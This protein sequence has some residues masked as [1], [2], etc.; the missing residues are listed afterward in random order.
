MLIASIA[1]AASLGT[2]TD[3][4][5]N[6]LKTNRQFFETDKTL[7]A[8][9]K[10]CVAPLK[11]QERKAFIDGWKKWVIS[12]RQEAEKRFAKMSPAY[13]Q[14]LIDH[15]ALQSDAKSK[16][17]SGRVG[18]IKGDD[19]FLTLDYDN[20]PYDGIIK[21]EHRLNNDETET[22]DNDHDYSLIWY[23]FQI[24]T[25]CQ[26]AVQLLQKEGIDALIER[27]QIDMKENPLDKN[28]LRITELE[29]WLKANLAEIHNNRVSQGQIKEKNAQI[30]SQMITEIC[31]WYKWGGD[32]S[33]PRYKEA[34]QRML[35]LYYDAMTSK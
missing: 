8:V 9:F 15:M 19:Y 7:N 25:Y 26:E 13:V 31:G 29:G 12:D 32:D 3:E 28:I 20:I 21:P 2:L 35:G 6:H 10:E 14:F 30:I 16:M 23:T 24:D 22:S 33:C 34:T 17:C 18:E 4:E 5:Y 27:A 11:G 1:V